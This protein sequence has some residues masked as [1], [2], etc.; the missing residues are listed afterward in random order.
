MKNDHKVK[1][2]LFQRTLLQRPD[3][4]VNLAIAA[5]LSHCRV[6]TKIPRVTSVPQLFFSSNERVAVYDF[7]EILC[8]V[9]SKF[10]NI[11][12]LTSTEFGNVL[13]LDNFISKQINIFDF[14]M[15]DF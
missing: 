4:E 2:K 14:M 9:D 13:V 6:P 12:V 1:A 10:Q 11:K 15:T 5:F 8:D 7:N 3:D